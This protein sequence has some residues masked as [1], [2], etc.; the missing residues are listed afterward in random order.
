MMPVVLSVLF[1][2]FVWWFGTG[3]VLY[4][5]GLPRFTF[6]ITMIVSSLVLA[7]AVA[8]MVHSSQ[9]VTMA[10]AYCAFT[11]AVLIWSWQ[12]IG[13]LLGYI[14]G[15]RKIELPANSRGWQRW[16][17]ALGAVNHHELA[18]LSL[19]LLVLWASWD[20]PNKTGLWTFLVLW[21]MR[22]SAKLNIFL[23]V[24]NLNGHF[25]P[26]HL[27]YLE[28]YFTQRPFNLLFP[29]SV[30]LATSLVIPMWQAAIGAVSE[31]QLVSGCLVATMLSLAILEH[32]L[33]ILP[34]RVDALWN[35]G[36][37]SR[38]N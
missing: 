7:G 23:G 30:T 21:V 8:G 13:F 2:L 26:T 14:T 9:M 24:R 35:W 31:F 4:L 1:A 37:A 32:W 38:H 28:S 33:M 34:I 11:C 6:P 22:Q 15:S 3:I 36:F 16:R 17:Y 19:F 12:E 18:L 29:V 27:R 5:N 10:G 25:L 20:A